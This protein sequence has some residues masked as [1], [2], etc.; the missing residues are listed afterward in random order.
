MA[1]QADQC[2]SLVWV[3]W[4]PSALPT[5]IHTTTSTRDTST[6]RSFP[7]FLPITDNHLLD[8]STI[9]KTKHF[10]YKVKMKR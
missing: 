1:G 6:R 4:I 10:Y 2:A 8:C 3:E 9:M 7:K 5:L